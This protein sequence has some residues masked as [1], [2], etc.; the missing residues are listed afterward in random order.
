MTMGDVV[1]LVRLSN[2]MTIKDIADLLNVNQS[3]VARIES[4][5]R[6]ISKTMINAYEQLFNIDMFKLYDEVRALTNFKLAFLKVLEFTNDGEEITSINDTLKL[7][8][9]A[10][11]LKIKELATILKMSPYYISDIENSKRVV[12]EKTL[13][14]YK[15]A[16]EIDIE[17]VYKIV[18][19]KKYSFKEG[20]TLVLEKLEFKNEVRKDKITC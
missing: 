15:E 14:R 10:N 6:K 16:F 7:V 17:Q 19:S 4:K 5:E 11:N 9:I 20:F 8:R 12:G 18:V 2:T 3:T 13:Y 1:K